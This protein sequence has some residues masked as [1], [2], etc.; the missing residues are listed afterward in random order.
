MAV[1]DNTTDPEAWAANT[2]AGI[3]PGL[4]SAAYSRLVPRRFGR[5]CIAAVVSMRPVGT[6]GNRGHHDAID[7]LDRQ[8]CRPSS[9]EARPGSGRLPQLGIPNFGR[10]ADPKGAAR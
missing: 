5:D 10:A 7:G 6:P 3:L 8:F 1:G 9:G 4:E 2:P